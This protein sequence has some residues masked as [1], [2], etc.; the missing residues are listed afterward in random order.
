MLTV[1]TFC[2]MIQLSISLYGEEAVMN[3]EIR[4]GKRAKK[5]LKTSWY[6][7]STFTGYTFALESA[8]GH[9]TIKLED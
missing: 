2:D 5:S 8:N 9:K 7:G 4:F 3:S 1:K 6:T